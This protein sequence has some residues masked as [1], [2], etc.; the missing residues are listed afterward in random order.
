M[1]P[2]VGPRAIDLLHSFEKC[3]LRAYLPTSKDRPTIGWGATFNPDGSAVRL[4]Q[5]WT[6][7]EAD[8]NF[9]VTV[10]VTGA[11]VAKLIGRAATTPIQFG[12][13]VCLAYNIGLRIDR[14][15]TSTVLH[16]HVEGDYAAAAAAFALWD[17][18]GGVVMAGLVR[19]RAA[20][21]AL[22]S[23]DMATF[24]RLVV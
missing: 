4:G 17:K 22:Y 23:G 8:R 15:P 7:P 11:A 14:F 10:A 19:R 1:T 9:A 13:L 18:Q 16:E 12:A 21:A 20:E 6:Q 3:R 2:F 5:V 24:D